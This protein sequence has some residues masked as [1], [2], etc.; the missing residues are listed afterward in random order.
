MHWSFQHLMRLLQLA[1]RLGEDSYAQ[2]LAVT[3]SQATST[4][5]CERCLRL[6]SVCST[7][8]HATH[9][10]SV[11]RTVAVADLLWCILR[12]ACRTLRCLEQSFLSQTTCLLNFLEA[13]SG[14]GRFASSCCARFFILRKVFEEVDGGCRLYPALWCSE[15]TFS[16]FHTRRHCAFSQRKLAFP[17]SR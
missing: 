1:I 10:R 15:F 9:S 5:T 8:R 13:F 4:T 6:G 12:I 14:T 17:P 3:L 11:L 16:A 2:A 7:K